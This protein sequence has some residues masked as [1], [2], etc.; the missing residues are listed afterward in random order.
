MNLKVK[1]ALAI[2]FAACAIVVEARA[3]DDPQEMF[4]KAQRASQSGDY[5]EAIEILR[6]LDEMN[7]GNPG[8]AFM[9]GYNLHASDKNEEAIKYHKFAAE[10]G[11]GESKILGLYNLAC[12]YSRQDKKDQAFETLEKSIVAGLHASPQAANT[13]SDSDFK[14]IKEDPRFAEMLAMIDNGGKR[15]K[16]KFTKKDLFGTWKVNM[17]MRSGAKVDSSRLPTIKI[18]DK[19]FTIP[20]GPGQ[21]F[22]M[23]YKL[24]LDAMPVKVDFKIESGPVP[25]GTAKGIIKLEKGEMSLCYEPMGGQRPK[26]FESTEE[27]GCFMFK[28]K[29]EAGKTAKVGMAM[30]ILGDWK[31]VKGLRAGAEVGAARMASVITIDEK[32]ITIPI[33]PDQAFKMSYSIDESKSPIAIDMKIEAGPVP[34]GKALGIIKMDGDKFVLCYDPQ[35]AQRPDKFESTEEDGRFLFEMK[36]E[37]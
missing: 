7:P 4:G 28:M 5:G 1:L 10:N 18:D 11:T 13:E 37:K 14:N 8:V 21:E 6:K 16:K 27:N 29:K 26:K 3:Q 23:S 31:C 2:L 20:G 12:A 34:E 36:A 33:G 25:D 32:M 15:P 30:K 35:G 22:V 24:D 17:G 9:L 19:A